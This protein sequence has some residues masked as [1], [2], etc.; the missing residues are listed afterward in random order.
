MTF[1]LEVEEHEP[2]PSTLVELYVVVIQQSGEAP[3][4]YSKT[5]REFS[6]ADAKAVELS[7]ERGLSCRIA[8]IMY[9]MIRG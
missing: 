7:A 4:M 3:R 6:G 8:M 5:Y 1:A 9:P 2:D